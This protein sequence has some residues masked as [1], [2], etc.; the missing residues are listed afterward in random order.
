MRAFGAGNLE[1][2][3]EVPEA[4]GH[5]PC[6]K[7]ESEDYSWHGGGAVYAGGGAS[8]GNDDLPYRAGRTLDGGGA[9]RNVIRRGGLQ[10]AK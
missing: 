10:N 9:L 8:G 1:G 2:T 5:I 7:G 6:E 4:G 3:A